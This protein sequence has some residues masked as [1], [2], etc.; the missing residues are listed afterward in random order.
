MGNRF[1][2][3]DMFPKL[4]P[5]KDLAFFTFITENDDNDAPV[6]GGCFSA[7]LKVVVYFILAILLI[8]ILIYMIGGR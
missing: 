5:N 7:W 1:I 4:D 2:E 8:F 6:R 3:M